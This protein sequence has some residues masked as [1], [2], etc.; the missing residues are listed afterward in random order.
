M[1]K[2]CGK[3]PEKQSKI[4]MSLSLSVLLGCGGTSSVPGVPWPLPGQKRDNVKNGDKGA[5]G[6]YKEFEGCRIP[7]APLQPPLRRLNAAEFDNTARQL[8]GSNASFAAEFSSENRVGSFDNS[9]QDQ[10]TSTATVEKYWSAAESLAG[11]TVNKYFSNC[12]NNLSPNCYGTSLE[13]LGTLVYRRPLFSDER[14]RLLS[15]PQS[16][17]KQGA[18]PADAITGTAMAMFLTPQF[19]F[20]SNLVE[21]E[22][23]NTR[24]FSVAERLSYFLWSSKP[25]DTL[26]ALA[27]AGKLADPAVVKEQVIR[28]LADP[29][30]NAFVENF[31][32]QWLGTRQMVKN[33][34]NNQGDLN[35]VQAFESETLAYFRDF[36][37]NNLNVRNLLDAKF[38]YLN[39]RLVNHYGL[40]LGRQFGQQLERVD[41]SNVPQRGGLLTQGAFLQ[42][43]SNPNQTSPVKR[44][45]W[46][47]EH[48]LCSPP[49]PA[50][51][52]QSA[53]FAQIDPNLPM[54][55][56]LAQHSKNPSC[57]G[58]H[59]TLD[60]LGLGFENYDFVGK[61]R[62][63]DG[64][65]RID[66]SGSVPGFGE[67]SSA[68]ELTQII[69]NDPRFPVCVART[70]SK[71]ALGR[72][73]SAEE[74]CVVNRV[75][76]KVV[77]PAY[78]FRDLLVDLSLA[79]L[80]E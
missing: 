30:A 77:D 32:G 13:R 6:T 29:R 51:S 41:L 22:S 23:S 20:R 61:W 59:V 49:K 25:D 66:P 10:V 72:E 68:A 47:L 45:I 27:A 50:P 8:L 15:M 69:Q 38:S 43:T 19:L 79:F 21:A 65:Q 9:I 2:V 62:T 26:N 12:L 39:A 46:L 60:P 53:A 64:G 78:G 34:Q 14:N 31:A 76:D 54:R 17:A 3:S 80:T 5:A 37:I 57:A 1:G 35:L 74:M 52:D 16:L 67:F 48:L 70:V 55:E 4:L 56:R 18:S 40:N 11:Q 36:M 44:G 42:Q 73:P 71:Y 7:T 33:A 24:L 58:C 63:L 28:M 75:A